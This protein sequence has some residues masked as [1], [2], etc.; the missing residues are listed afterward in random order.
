MLGR[1]MKKV[2]ITLDDKTVAGA[3]R[4]ATQLNLSLS[5]LISS[6]L[7]QHLKEPQQYA[8]AMRRYLA[9]SPTLL[10]AR[11]DGYPGRDELHDRSSLR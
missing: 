4:L 8:Q 3:R 2:T 1:A 10:N 7:K 5:R 6:V 9:R 11:D